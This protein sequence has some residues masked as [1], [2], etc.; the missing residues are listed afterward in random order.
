MNRYISTPFLHRVVEKDGFVFVGGSSADDTSKDIVGQM[1]ETI[2]K[3]ETYLAAAGSDKT[4][5][6]FAT[7]YIANLG[8][9]Q[10]MSE[11]WAEW[12]PSGDMPARATICPADLGGDMLVEI[13]L[14]AHT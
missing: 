4:K 2:A 6:V 12:I 8:L 1:H 13:T 5:I 7:I 3:L 10:A 11:V 14:I 9:K